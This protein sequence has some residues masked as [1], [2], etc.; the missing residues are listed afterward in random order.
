MKYSNDSIFST[1]Y[2]K[3]ENRND[4]VIVYTENQVFILNQTSTIIWHYIINRMAFKDIVHSFELL[5]GK[6]L[7]HQDCYELVELAIEQM[8]EKGIVS[9]TKD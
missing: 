5:V 1:S 6:D 8:L 3:T 9:I 4:C 7:P 2:V